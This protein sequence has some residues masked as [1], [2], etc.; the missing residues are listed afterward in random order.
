MTGAYVRF[1]RDGVWQSLE[2]DELTEEE[3]IQYASDHPADGWMW[4][5]FLVKWLKEAAK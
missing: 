1:K 3:L 2:I 4:A 5:K